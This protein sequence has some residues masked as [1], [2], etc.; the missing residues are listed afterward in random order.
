MSEHTTEQQDRLTIYEQLN[1]AS[2]ARRDSG[3]IHSGWVHYLQNRLS[4][5]GGFVL[6]AAIQ[7]VVDRIPD[8]FPLDLPERVAQAKSEGS[9]LD[10]TPAQIE[11][12]TE[13][14]KNLIMPLDGAEIIE[15]IKG[16][17]DY[18]EGK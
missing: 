15:I 16:V 5:D 6:K 8:V 18:L 11:A 10:P 17:K 9:E 12:I 1:A 14:N 4:N 2:I 13:I 3:V 7:E